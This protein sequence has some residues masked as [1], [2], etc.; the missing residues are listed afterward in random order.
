MIGNSVNIRDIELNLE[1]LVLPEN[2]LSD[3]SLSPDL[4]PEEEEQQAYRVDTCCSTCGT[5]VRVSVL[6][7]RSAIRIL[8]GLL[9]HELSLFCP[10][11]SRLHL[12]H[13]RSR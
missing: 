11:C 13:G 12:Q 7:T 6:A 8:Q 1:A 9:L 5:G 3:E 4:V 10:Q 2:L